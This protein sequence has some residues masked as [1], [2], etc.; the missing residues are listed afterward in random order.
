MAPRIGLV[1][2]G[3]VGSALVERFAGAGFHVVGYDPR[4]EIFDALSQYSLSAAES[5][6]EVATQVERIVL[7]LPNTDVVEQVIE[8]SCGILSAGRAGHVIID[9][10]TGDPVRSTQLAQR[11]WQQGF[12]Y[13]DATIMASSQQVRVGD[14]ITLVGGP[15]DAIEAQ[16]DIFGAFANQVLHM[17]PNGKGMEA[18]LVA[19]LVIGLNRLV[20]AEGLALG[21]HAGIDPDA[22][23]QMLQSGL[24]YSR[25]MDSKGQK[26]V[27][28]NFE[29]IG[30]LQQH[31]KDVSLILE[32]GQRVDSP[33]PLSEIHAAILERAVERGYGE[34]DNSAVIQMFMR[35]R[36][37][38]PDHHE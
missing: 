31:L 14:A 4:T 8:G 25:V 12:Q 6:Q 22:V 3:L 32:M 24:A 9:T 2:L 1:G 36:Q 13:L 28:G 29:P 10:T 30:R 15:A 23:L 19:N 27:T 38:T 16:Q 35:N 20:L 5:P 21:I 34:V 37:R 17:G 7:S 26:M 33:L 11:L 18:K